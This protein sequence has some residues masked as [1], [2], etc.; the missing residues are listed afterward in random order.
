VGSR[1]RLV[2]LGAL[3]AVML[4]LFW[5]VGRDVGLVE[6]ETPVDTVSERD[7]A[8]EEPP[9]RPE[10][11]TPPPRPVPEPAPE[12]EGWIDGYVL[13]PDGRPV[14][15]A[16]S[17]GDEIDSGRPSR[18]L[19][20]DGDGYFRF[21][22]IEVRARRALTV[23]VRNKAYQP[24]R[25]PVVLD[26]ERP[27]ATV[28]I[29]LEGPGL[30]RGLVLDSEDEPVAGARIALMGSGRQEQSDLTGGFSFE[31][32]VFPIGFRVTA[33]GFPVTEATFALPRDLIEIRLRR[34]AP[35]TARVIDEETRRPIDRF[36]YTALGPEVEDGARRFSVRGTGR[37]GE[38]LLAETAEEYLLFVAADGYA[39]ELH[40]VRGGDGAADATMVIAMGRSSERIAGRAVD[41]LG[42]IVPGARV[43]LDCYS[44]LS[45][46]RRS[47]LGAG[48]REVAPIGIPIE[49]VSDE[50]GRFDF[51][52]PR[53]GAYRLIASS[54]RHM[55]YQGPDLQHAA[56][57]ILGDLDVTL[58]EHAALV[59]TY[60]ETRFP[61]EVRISVV[62]LSR[63]LTHQD[64][65]SGGLIRIDPIAADSYVVTLTDHRKGRPLM[66]RA[67]ATLEPGERVEVGLGFTSPVSLTGRVLLGDE[68][69]ADG[70]VLL[71][72]N[73]LGWFGARVAETDA[74]GVFHLDGIE[75]G[76]YSLHP[77]FGPVDELAMMSIS[78]LEAVSGNPHALRRF[79]VGAEPLA[80]DFHFPEP[81][82]VE[83][84]VLDP[85]IAAVSLERMGRRE[86][87]RVRVLEDGVFAFASV[88]PGAYDLHVMNEAEKTLTSQL[89]VM[90]DPAVDLIV[91]D[92]D[93]ERETELV[94]ACRVGAGAAL[95][96]TLTAALE[97]DGQRVFHRAERLAGT[98]RYPVALFRRGTCS[99]G[100]FDMEHGRISA[101][102]RLVVRAGR[103]V[104]LSVDL[105][106]V[107]LLTIRSDPLFGNPS[108]I[109]IEHPE[110]GTRYRLDEFGL[111]PDLLRER[112]GY[113]SSGLAYF[114]SVEPG[115]WT[116]RTVDARGRASVR[117]VYLEPGEPVVL[118]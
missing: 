75:P 72:P 48:S 82:R 81:G 115:H 21:G 96:R 49:A 84:L 37:D 116:V 110:S 40:H 19:V 112:R 102:H 6:V 60:P 47:S 2:V 14:A 52:R 76:D 26:P 33:A 27:N 51:I 69:F 59:V 31:D 86:D 35:R 103:R 83:G 54:P 58:S 74:G 42:R 106:P 5:W 94:L 24:S 16:L 25:T 3:L 10:S 101:R 68:P 104:E 32:L 93:L 39:P 100:V 97:Q 98:D 30:V 61:D 77:W 18:K 71:Y 92:L 105:E 53:H 108:L 4:L 99:I 95:P 113:V 66:V 56:P 41:H 36:R 11:R 109:E 55:P 20:S 22:G 89:I 1:A 44:E 9:E 57:G 38:I 65:T 79:S 80:R 114:H 88:L 64:R 90:P 62:G 50:D 70:R 28:R 23:T 78:L 12:R 8:N 85:R 87:E 29:R 46:E 111:A 45:S 67:K 43:V 107:T 15:L 34:N 63:R 13:G 17:L 73:P 7:R 118:R 117:Y 91:G